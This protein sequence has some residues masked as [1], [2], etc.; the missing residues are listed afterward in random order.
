MYVQYGCGFSAPVQ[1]TNFDASP[2][3][4]WERIPILG[5]LYTKNV[6]RFPSGVKYGDIVDGLPVADNSCGG[7][8][9]SHVLE[10]LTLDEFHKALENTRKILQDG[11]IFRLVV[12]D[13]ESAARRYLKQLESTNASACASFLEETSLGTKE[14][15]RNLSGLLYAWL[16]SSTHLW[17]WDELSLAQALEQHGFTQIRRCSCGDCVDPMFVFVEDPGRFEGAVAMEARKL[18][19]P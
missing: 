19:K 8:Y 2:T 14:R 10:H 3:L 5:K 13:L 11:G 1:W 17:M 4:R 15:R 16:G 12:P 9:A 7:V 6:Q 18:H